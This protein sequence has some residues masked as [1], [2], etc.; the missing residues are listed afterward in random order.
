VELLLA[1]P[2]VLETRAGGSRRLRSTGS[3]LGYTLAA[4]LGGGLLRRPRAISLIVSY[5]V[6]AYAMHAT[7]GQSMQRDGMAVALRYQL[8]H[9][10]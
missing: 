6:A 8:S 1:D 5:I 9:L 10:E 3:S 2:L 4:L 7:I